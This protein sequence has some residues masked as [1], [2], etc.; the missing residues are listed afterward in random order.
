MAQC[1]HS[2]VISLADGL[3]PYCCLLEPG[4]DGPHCIGISNDFNLVC[5][6]HDK[7]GLFGNC[8]DCQQSLAPK[9]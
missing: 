1:E 6:E 2:V 5:A 7:T 4:H 3:G 8:E 9:S